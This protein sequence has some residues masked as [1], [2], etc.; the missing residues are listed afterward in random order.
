MAGRPRPHPFQQALDANGTLYRC[1]HC[2]M[3]D[4]FPRMA[5]HVVRFHTPEALVPFLCSLCGLRML[6]RTYSQRHGRTHH[7]GP[8]V[9]LESRVPLTP[10]TLRNHCAP[11]NGAF[12]QRT[13]S[14]LR[15]VTPP[16]DVTPVSIRWGKS[17]SVFFLRRY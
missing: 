14:A 1:L 16:R 4:H 17:E 15:A 7:S 5:T 8:S 9:I 11:I 2:H 10:Y 12:A 6:N 3:V 13:L